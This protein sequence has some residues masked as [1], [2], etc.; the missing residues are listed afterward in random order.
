MCTFDSI[1]IPSSIAKC[2][3]INKTLRRP[4]SRSW[5]RLLRSIASQ[6]TSQPRFGTETGYRLVVNLLSFLFSY[7]LTVFAVVCICVKYERNEVT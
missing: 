5:S 6:S 4:M 1:K 3:I 2:D 7:V